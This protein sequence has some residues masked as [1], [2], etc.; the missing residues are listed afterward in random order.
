MG[1]QFA[2]TPYSKLYMWRI[3]T[4]WKQKQWFRDTFENV[5]LLKKHSC[6]KASSLMHI[7]K[8]L[9]NYGLSVGY[10]SSQNS[11]KAHLQPLLHKS[12]QISQKKTPL[13]SIFGLIN[14]GFPFKSMSSCCFCAFAVAVCFWQWWKKHTTLFIG[15]PKTKG[16]I[17]GTHLSTEQLQMLYKTLCNQ[18]QSQLKGT[19][20][21]Y[22]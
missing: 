6:R 2:A 18:I 5:L 14:V 11:P 13:L 20:Q 8:Y 19:G 4:E 9:S 22:I 16:R 21:A 1:Q 17:K 12:S 15:S 10:S 3:S 7:D